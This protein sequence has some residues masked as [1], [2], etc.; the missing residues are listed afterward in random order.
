[1]TERVADAVRTAV[2]EFFE[3]ELLVTFDDEVKPDTDLFKAGI[4]RSRDYLRILV[5][6]QRDLGVVMT[7]EELF[8]NVLVSLDGVAEFVERKQAA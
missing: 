4:I 6:L 8:A 5:F 3:R 2:R 1:M 7:D